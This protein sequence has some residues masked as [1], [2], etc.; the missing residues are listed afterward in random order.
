MTV[1]TA[2]DTATESVR[3]R[4]LLGTGLRADL[5]GVRDL[6]R[7]LSL[8]R[9]AGGVDLDVVEGLDAFAQDLA[10][11]LTT[12]RGTDP[13]NAR[14]GFLGLGPLTDQTAPSIARQALRSAVAQVV[15]ADPRVRR[16]VDVTVTTPAAGSRVLD[17]RVTFDAISGDTV[18]VGVTGSEA[19]Q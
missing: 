5:V 9:T 19:P 14:F 11:A 15:A 8:R 1:T 2:T 10:V 6:A 3:R 7:D 16:I 17:I 4:R 18:T 13:F 12:L